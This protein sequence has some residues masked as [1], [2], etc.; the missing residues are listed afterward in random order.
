M[1]SRRGGAR[2]TSLCAVALLGME[3]NRDEEK[4]AKNL[5]GLAPSS[6]Y[7]STGQQGKA[8]NSAYHVIKYVGCRF[9]GLALAWALG[10]TNDFASARVASTTRTSCR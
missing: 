1:V 2:I 8:M 6:R 9:L 7:S 5:R 10:V 3:R 4:N